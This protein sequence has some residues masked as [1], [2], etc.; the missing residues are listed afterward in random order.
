MPI[1]N[2]FSYVPFR[3]TKSQLVTGRSI[4]DSLLCQTYRFEGEPES[5]VTMIMVLGVPGSPEGVELIK[6]YHQEL[7]PDGGDVIISELLTHIYCGLLDGME[8]TG[9]PADKNHMRIASR[10]VLSNFHSLLQRY[11][12]KF[13]VQQ[14]DTFNSGHLI[15]TESLSAAR[16]HGR[17]E[18]RYSMAVKNTVT[19]I[20]K[21]IAW[22]DKQ[23]ADIPL[24][25]LD[26]FRKQ[27]A[28]DIQYLFDEP[29]VN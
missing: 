9:K 28:A 23:V 3:E 18:Y 13:Q 2:F 27:Y 12:I 20:A 11:D 25:S 26:K 17:A 24:F 6:K 16:Y 21:S 1:G 8:F 4:G 19:G 10:D 22:E 15:L 7:P 14:E 29:K 5:Y